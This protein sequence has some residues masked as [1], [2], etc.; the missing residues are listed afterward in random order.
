MRNAKIAI[1]LTVLGELTFSSAIF[2]IFFMSKGFS[3]GELGIYFAVSRLSQALLEI[4][5]SS[6]ADK[7]GRKSSIQ[8][9]RIACMVIFALLIFSNNFL[10]III[11]A[12]LEGVRAALYSDSHTSMVYDSLQKEGKTDY[13][14]KFRAYY[15]AAGFIAYGTGSLLGASLTSVV[16]MQILFIMRFPILLAHLVLVGLM[17]E[18]VPK[19]FGKTGNRAST[20]E[21]KKSI[22][23]IL[24]NRQI[25]KIMY[26]CALIYAL[27]VIIWDYY[28]SYG[29]AI[30]I[31]LVFFGWA[32]VGFSI[33]E[34]L[35]Q[36]LSYKFV[37]P[38]SFSKLYT[39]LIITMTLLGIGGAVLQDFNGF[40]LLILA[41]MV[42]GLTFPIT[43]SILHEHAGKDHRITVASFNTLLSML[44]YALYTLITGT[45]ANE[46]SI[47]MALGTVCGIT[48]FF[49]LV[50]AFF[51]FVLPKIKEKRDVAKA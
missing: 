30:D 47:F 22:T 32:A 19:N 28:Q 10:V 31:P 46:T 20:A 37:N 27:N 29:A 4:P 42:S 6:F 9:S 48:L 50:Y 33:A 25:L 39:S 7:F 13:Y 12:L 16:P 17:K 14:P 21:I 43:D 40:I 23:H 11:A 38:S 44:V 18:D 8:L 41:V 34:A 1:F 5:C 26:F 3:I 24:H 15:S 35:P 51:R 49:T 45:I 36:F 2:N